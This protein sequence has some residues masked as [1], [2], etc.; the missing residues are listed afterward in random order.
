MLFSVSLNPLF[1]VDFVTYVCTLIFC[2]GMHCILSVCRVTIFPCS[3]L[4][5]YC[6]RCI[7]IRMTAFSRFLSSEEAIFANHISA[8]D[9]DHASYY[10]LQKVL[11]HSADCA[12]IQLHTF[13][14]LEKV[15]NLLSLRIFSKCIAPRHKKIAH[16]SSTLIP[17]FRILLQFSANMRS[18][19]EQSSLFLRQFVVFALI[20]SAFQQ[21][22]QIGMAGSTLFALGA[23][24]G[25][26]ERTVPDDVLG[27]VGDKILQHLSHPTGPDADIPD[28]VGGVVGDD[29]LSHLR[30][31]TGPDVGVAGIATGT[32]S[33]VL[34]QASSDIHNVE[35]EHPL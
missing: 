23:P 3:L 4:S 14:I 9:A 1:A 2:H 31:T 12:D 34:G 13:Y 7:E 27:A 15:L 32:A 17:N 28:T 26:Q 20:A 18:F 6:E 25:I 5:Q 11:F 24:I 10:Q 22:F 16:S 19:I 35:A 8:S 33:N 29:V 30:R 21:T